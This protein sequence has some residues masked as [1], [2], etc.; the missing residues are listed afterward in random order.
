VK[1]LVVIPNYSTL[2]QDVAV[3]ADC[4]KSIRDT[5]GDAVDIV[6]VD[7]G[8]PKPSLVQAVESLG[9]KWGFS[10]V[11]KEENSGFSATV[12]VGL[13]RALDEGRDAIL[14]NADIEMMG[15]G[16]L[17]AM[18][19]CPSLMGKDCKPAIVGGLLA[20]PN[21]LIQHGGVYFSLLTREFDHMFKFAPMN[22]PQ[23]LEPR[24]CPV[25]AALH[26]IRHDNLVEVGLYDESFKMG[27]E[28]VD[29]CL[30][31]MIADRECVYNPNVRAWHAESMF[32]GR[33][34]PKI[35]DWQQ[36]SWLRL[37]EKYRNQSFAGMVP[38]Q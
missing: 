12:N 36:R 6:V 24:V 21:G 27:W 29:Y 32:R 7:D 15:P 26:F 13:K 23:A 34:S 14:C 18:V 5:E 17:D 25:T 33:P 19:N 11:A 37:A 16:W 35:R 10:F 38:F 31:T 20:F 2:P 8:S 30:R 9:S 28:D 1:P 22:L 4:V 3:L